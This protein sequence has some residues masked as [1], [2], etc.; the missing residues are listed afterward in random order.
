MILSTSGPACG[1]TFQND[2][3]DIQDLKLSHKLTL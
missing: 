2:R 1:Q 3:I